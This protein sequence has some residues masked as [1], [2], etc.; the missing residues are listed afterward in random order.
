MLILTRRTG[1]KI[2]INQGQIEVTILY[3]GTDHASIG[4]KAPAHKEL[5]MR[6][7][8]RRIKEEILI[9]DD[10]I[11]LKVLFIFNGHVAIGIQAPAHIDVDRKEIF[12]KKRMDKQMTMNKTETPETTP[13]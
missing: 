10:Q 4:F 5:H 3:V 2:I 13:E 12:L 7:F 9:D 8:T 1:K 6:V 11:K